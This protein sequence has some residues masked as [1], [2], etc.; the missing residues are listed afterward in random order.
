MEELELELA[1]LLERVG[2]TF[3]EFIKE[4]FTFLANFQ[5]ILVRHKLPCL[6]RQQVALRHRP[7]V[8]DNGRQMFPY[9]GGRAAK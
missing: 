6:F 8:D 9:F 2:L 7:R 3:A 4:V 5:F 1:E